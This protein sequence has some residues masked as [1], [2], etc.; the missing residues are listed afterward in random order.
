MEKQL[1]NNQ[2]A[3]S[4]CIASAWVPFA[5]NLARVLE[6]L[7]EDQYLIITAKRS[8]RHVQVRRTGHTW[9]ADGND[10]Q[11]LPGE[12]RTAHTAA[13][14]SVEEQRMAKEGG[15]RGCSEARACEMAF[16]QG[17]VLPDEAALS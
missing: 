14:R 7:Q 13:D 8:N 5:Q 3:S 1:E 2:I 11:P 10:K 16:T 15:I 6:G 9:V 12:I 17:Q 4:P